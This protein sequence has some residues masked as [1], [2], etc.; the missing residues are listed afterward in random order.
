MTDMSAPAW[1]AKG[2]GAVAG[3]AVS[4]ALHPAIRPPRGCLRARRGRE[5][6]HG[7]REA[8]RAAVGYGVREE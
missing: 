8:K 5:F 6:P 1:A 7:R 4:L 3:S 2:A